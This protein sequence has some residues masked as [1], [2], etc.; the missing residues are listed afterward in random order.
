MAAL[1]YHVRRGKDDL[2][3]LMRLLGV[4]GEPPSDVL[5]AGAEEFRLVLVES[6][7][8][9]QLPRPPYPWESERQRRYVIMAIRQGLIIVP[10]QR[11]GAHGRGWDVGAESP[12]RWHVRNI[13]PVATYI[14]GGRQ[15]NYMKMLGW[16]KIPAV[17]TKHAERIRTKMRKVLFRRWSKNQL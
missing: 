16:Q 8:P 4:V 3:D 10:H 7:P 6:Y 12:N 9:V 15:S 14:Q 2:P 11:T 1:D 5:Q 17:Y 13:N